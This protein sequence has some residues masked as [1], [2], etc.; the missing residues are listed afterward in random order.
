MSMFKQVK[1]FAAKQ[2]IGGPHAMIPWLQKLGLF[3]VLAVC[4]TR[5]QADYRTDWLENM[6]PITP[7]TYVCRHAT[8]PIKI[9]GLLD[10]PAW[11]AAPWTSDFVDIQGDAKPKPRFRTRVKMLWDKNYLYIAAELEEPNVWATLTQH[12]SVIF[13]DPDF[14]V[15]MDPKGETQPYYEFEMNAL[16]TTWDLRLNKPYIDQGKPDNAWESGAKTAVHVYGTLNHPGDT[17]KGWTVEIAFPWKVLSK[18]ARHSGPPTEGEQWRINFSRVEWQI[19]TNGGVYRKVPGVPEDNWVWSP[20]GVVDMHR[21]EMWGLVQFTDR[22]ANQA[23]S[24]APIPGK[25]A[26]DLALE[27]YYAQKDFWNAHDRWATNLTELH[28]PPAKLPADVGHVD[29]KTTTDGY[30]CAVP[31][32]ADG[33]RHVWRIRQDHLLKLDEPM[34]MDTQH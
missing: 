23:I 22:P 9:D 18:D 8:E 3:C 10:D 1:P 32:R 11:A 20:Q 24:V 16:N 14:E 34:P 26:R 21:P 29:F 4:T 28:L 6:Q 7:H 30:I 12:D 27:V 31:F 2:R 5:A 13:H 17:D 19:T 15:F 33:S 25:P